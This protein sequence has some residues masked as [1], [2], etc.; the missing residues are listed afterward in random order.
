MK[1]IAVGN[2][3]DRYIVVDEFGGVFVYAGE[4]IFISQLRMSVTE[5]SKLVVSGN[6]RFLAIGS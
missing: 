5:I 2:D 1:I 4:G 3:S 6:A